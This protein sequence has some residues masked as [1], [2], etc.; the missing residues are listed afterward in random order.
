MK[1]IIAAFTLFMAFS[2]GAF[3]QENKATNEQL[4]K[5]QAVTMVKFLNLDENRI[6]EFKN[7]FLMKE[8]LMNNPEASDDRKNIMSQVVAAKIQASIN[9]KQ[10][11]KLVANTALYNQL[12]GTDKLKSKK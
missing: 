6:E 7:L 11:E 4:A 3:A 8:E 10:L 9:G 12:V 2:M 1:K 5:N